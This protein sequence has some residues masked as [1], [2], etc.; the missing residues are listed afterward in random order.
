MWDCSTRNRN[1]Q[2][3][4]STIKSTTTTTQSKAPQQIK[5]RYGKCLDASQRNRRGGKVHMWSCN[6]KNANQ[7][8]AYNAGTHQIKAV[9]GI[10]L[11]ASQR[12]HK[13]GKVHMWSCNTRNK[14]Q[15]WKYTASTGQIKSRYGKCLDASQRNRNGGKVH[16][17]DCST[18]NR[19]QQWV[20]PKAGGALVQLRASGRRRRKASDCVHPASD[21]PESWD[22]ECG[23]SLH[24]YCPDLQQN[25]VREQMCKAGFIC[26]DWK[27]QACPSSMLERAQGKRDAS[28]EIANSSN[29]DESLTTKKTCR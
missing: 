15:Q 14:N 22:C 23:E 2:W 8:W 24:K 16:M 26:D 21:D 9:H 12:N 3:V 18:R 20:I 13:G 28:R 7:Q 6:K 10:C 27:Q 25:C 17:W 29:L 19:N 11:D 5:S 1:Q 4:K